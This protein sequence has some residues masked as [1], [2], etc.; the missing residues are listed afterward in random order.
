MTT[1]N[2]LTFSLLAAAVLATPDAHGQTAP[3][4]KQADSAA[5]LAAVQRTFDAMRTHDTLVLRAV[6]D[7][8]ARIV[9]TSYDSLGSPR[10][11]SLPIDRFIAAVGSATVPWNERIWNPEV[12]IDDNIATVWTAYDFHAG[13]E[14]SHCGT[15]AIQLVRRTDGWKIVHIIDTHRT[16]GC[17]QRREHHGH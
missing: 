4:T 9:A 1:R 10:S 6:F 13:Q 2:L 3:P 5:V 11:R 16:A 7:S 14:F 12:R 8:G 17:E 15:D